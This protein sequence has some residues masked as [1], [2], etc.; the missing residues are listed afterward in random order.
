MA[1]AAPIAGST[2]RG[3]ALGRSDGEAVAEVGAVPP[4]PPTLPPVTPED[5]PIE[6]EDPPPT[7]VVPRSTGGEGDNTFAAVAFT[8]FSRVAAA[9]GFIGVR[10]GE[11]ATDVD[12]DDAP[13][14]VLDGKNG[15]DRGLSDILFGLLEPLPAGDVPPLLE[16]DGKITDSWR[17]SSGRPLATAKPDETS[18]TGGVVYAYTNC[19]CEP[20]PAEPLTVADDCISTN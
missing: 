17:R 8:A 9:I 11:A 7:L 3:A 14:I 4:P 16:V 1:E 19:G 2:E 18:R 20:P 5:A 6:L 10:A 12:A 15:R 13:D